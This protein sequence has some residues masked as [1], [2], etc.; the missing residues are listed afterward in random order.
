[1]NFHILN[2]NNQIIFFLTLWALN[3]VILWFSFRLCLNPSRRL[4]IISA[5]CFADPHVSFHK[6]PWVSGSCYSISIWRIIYLYVGM[7]RRKILSFLPVS[8]SS[9]L[10]SLAILSIIVPLHRTH[11]P[12]FYFWMT[13]LLLIKYGVYIWFCPVLYD[14]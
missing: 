5:F 9:M 11:R 2:I 7:T 6:S 1:M 14:F 10:P 4:V 13:F 3:K 8:A 12:P